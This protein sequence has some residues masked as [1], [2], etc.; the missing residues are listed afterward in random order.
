MIWLAHWGSFN[1]H[2][3]VMVGGWLEARD[4]SLL[5]FFAHPGYMKIDWLEVIFAHFSSFLL[6]FAHAVYIKNKWLE[7]GSAHFC[8]FLLIFAHLG[9][10]LLI[11]AH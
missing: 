10:C 8:S 2:K 1:V 4:C 7:V 6:I 9:S 11:V 5:L 3:R